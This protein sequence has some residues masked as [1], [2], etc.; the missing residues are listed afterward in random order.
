MT[1]SQEILPLLGWPGHDVNRNRCSHDGYLEQTPT[2]FTQADGS[3]NCKYGGT[4]LGLT[5]SKRIAQLMGGD[6][7]VIS[8]KGLGST[9]WATVKLRKG[10]EVIATPSAENVQVGFSWPDSR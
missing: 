4:G 6:A 10:V 7:G 3:M 8:E 2:A 9:F 5:I 1:Q